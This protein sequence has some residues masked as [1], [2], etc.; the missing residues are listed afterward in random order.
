MKYSALF[1]MAA[2][3]ALIKPAEPHGGAGTTQYKM[4]NEF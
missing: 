3:P 4:K 1:P 2:R